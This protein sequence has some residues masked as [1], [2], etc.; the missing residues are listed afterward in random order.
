[1]TETASSEDAPAMV[2]GQPVE[3]TISQHV[4]TTAVSNFQLIPENGG[5]V[6]LL[7]ARHFNLQERGF[8]NLPSPFVEIFPCAYLSHAMLKD[9]ATVLNNAVKDFERLFGKIP[10]PGLDPQ[11]PNVDSEK[12]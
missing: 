5:Y 12:K 10:V 2:G 7:G 8:A 1:M 9:M 4:A 11:L 3:K 6:L